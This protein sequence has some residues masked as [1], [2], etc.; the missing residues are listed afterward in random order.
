MFQGLP[1]F[2]IQPAQPLGVFVGSK[3][4]IPK[5]AYVLPEKTSAKNHHVFWN[6]SI[7][8][9][10]LPLLEGCRFNFLKY[11]SEKSV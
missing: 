6:S 4:A 5:K 9:T 3:N 11:S 10:P 1:N 2:E 8:S 7:P